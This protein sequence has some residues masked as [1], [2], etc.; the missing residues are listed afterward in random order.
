MQTSSEYPHTSVSAVFNTFDKPS[1]TSS[2]A[3]SSEKA[4]N[5]LAVPIGLFLVGLVLG[6]LLGALG[7]FLYARFRTKFDNANSS[8]K[9]KTV[10]YEAAMVT[11]NVEYLND[12]NYVPLQE[13]NTNGNDNMISHE[14]E[15]DSIE[16]PMEDHYNTIDE[17]EIDFKENYETI[18]NT[19]IRIT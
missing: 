9:D 15:F 3:K 7:W 11:E 12:P 19:N 18:S 5:A 4:A 8:D 13:Q 14:R 1:T 17:S 6:A 10:G 2:K 16:S